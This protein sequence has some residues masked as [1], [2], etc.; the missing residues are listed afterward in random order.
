M[1]TDSAKTK[2]LN[3]D[4]MMA[5]VQI[6]EE[7][8]LH[9]TK[10]Y[11]E[12]LFDAIARGDLQEA[13]ACMDGPMEGQAGQ[14]SK[15]P[16]RQERYMFVVAAAFFSRAAIRGGV[17]PEEAFTITDIYCQQM[18]ELPD[19]SNYD[20][21]YAGLVETLVRRVNE[22]RS[23]RESYSPVIE[24]CQEYMQKHMQEAISLSE[25]AEQAHLSKRWLSRRF[26]EETGVSVLDYLRQIRLERACQ[27]LKYTNYSLSE[28]SCLL[29]FSS[30]SH[31]SR[32]FHDA[33]HVT[34]LQYR[35]QGE[36]AR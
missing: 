11:E 13:F 1:K 27:L 29:Q 16:F 35:K 22:I 34:P 20:S 24:G 5:Q 9:T 8:H 10:S 19:G 26:L 30:Q 17:S 12:A 25:I 33:Y 6:A 2:T 15:D 21:L 32:V 18:D 31:F 14:M 36:T 23:G 7:H 4:V 3:R 28:I